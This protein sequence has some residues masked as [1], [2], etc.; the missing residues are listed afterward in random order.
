MRAALEYALGLAAQ[1]VP[2]FP[3]RDDKRPACVHGF[4]D[5]T[6][7]AAELRRLWQQY[8]GTLV[9]VPTGERFCVLDLDLQHQEAQ[10]WYSRANLPKTRIHHTRSGGRHV[11]FKSHAEFTCTAGKIARGVDSR[12]RGGYVCWWPAVGLEVI[13]ANV[14]ADVPEFLLRGLRRRPELVVV[15][16]A[17]PSRTSRLTGILAAAVSAKEG[18]RNCV[19]FWAACRINA[20]LN[21]GEICSGEA[22]AALAALSSISINNGLPRREV[23]QT[24]ASAR[25]RL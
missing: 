14:L 1:G 5:A 25:R 2:A 10:V 20:M 19:T 24:I 17:T 21:E 18:E 16:T 8:P 12:G 13:D 15:S 7:D 22:A 11:L 4:K 23:E 3:C 6:A 9:G